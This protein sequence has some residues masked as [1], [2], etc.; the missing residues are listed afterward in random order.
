MELVI[1]LQMLNFYP[2]MFDTYLQMQ[3]CSSSLSEHK[4]VFECEILRICISTFK[5]VNAFFEKNRL[6]TS[7]KI[8]K[9]V[10]HKNS[11]R[12]H[13]DQNIA[14]KVSL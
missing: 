3:S 4:Y 8:F 2:S 10:K 5:N 12:K 6:V 11:H 13:Y 1:P 7:E 9:K 14:V